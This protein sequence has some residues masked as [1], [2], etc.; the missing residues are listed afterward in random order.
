MMEKVFETITTAFQSLWKIKDYGK[1]LEIVT[2]VATINNMFVSVFITKRGEDYIATDGGWIDSG[3]Y[4]CEID[5]KSHIFK[6]IGTYYIE[7]L[8]IQKEETKGRTF[9]YKRINKLELLPN[10]VFDLSNFINAIISSS[11]IKFTADREEMTFKKD[12]RG[13]MRREFGDDRFEYEKSLS[14]DSTIRFNAIERNRNGVKLINFVGGSNSTYYANS[15][16]RSNTNFQMI[17]PYHHKFN[18]KRTITLLD[19]RKPSVINSPQVQTYFNYL[20]ENQTDGN[21]VVLWS[22]RDELADAV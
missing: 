15:L 8:D 4:E 6:R 22:H 21:R 1:T 5:W 10:I 16:C 2:P 19:D 14:E 17:Q 18:I 7:N 9:Y 3:L 11:N 12:V 20:M 13:Y